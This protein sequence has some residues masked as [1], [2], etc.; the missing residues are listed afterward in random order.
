VCSPVKLN[1]LTKGSPNSVDQ[2]SITEASSQTFNDGPV[3]SMHYPYGAV[4]RD[5]G[6][7]MA[8]EKWLCRAFRAAEGTFR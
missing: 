1:G 4:M 8:I 7:S 6:V 2:A 5:D 3:L